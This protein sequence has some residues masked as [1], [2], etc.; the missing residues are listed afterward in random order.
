VYYVTTKTQ[1]G[2]KVR[3]ITTANK[4]DVARGEAGRLGGTCR[5]QAEIDDL[6]LKDRLDRTSL[7]GYVAPEPAAP[8]VASTP[9]T[10]TTD[11]PS[12]TGRWNDLA[13]SLATAHRKANTVSTKDR[14]PKR[15]ET[16]AA[17]LEQ[18]EAHLRA[19]G[20]GGASKVHIVRNLANWKSPDGQQL[21]RRDALALLAKTH[22]NIAAATVS[23]QW[24]V[25][26]GMPKTSRQEDAT[27][28]PEAV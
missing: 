7:P 24:Q 20:F 15:V 27:G 21:Q 11:Q 6:I 5:T 18:A 10:E 17:V 14:A 12:A 8:V 9:V 19:E 3:V 16:P 22:P 26:R 13:T 4:R 28:K 2:V 25:A 23:T 1:H